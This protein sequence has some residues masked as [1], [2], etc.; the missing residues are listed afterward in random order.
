MALLLNMD[1]CRCP[2][3]QSG[4]FKLAMKI[5][6]SRKS[7]IHTNNLCEN[8]S[9]RGFSRIWTF[10]DNQNMKADVIIKVCQVCLE[11]AILATVKIYIIKRKIH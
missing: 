4:R 7:L 1:I 8:S 2:E 11:L 6:P 3:Y 9:E 5:C 10:A